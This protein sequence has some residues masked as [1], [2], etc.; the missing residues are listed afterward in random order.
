MKPEDF[1]ATAA[2]WLQVIVWV[3]IALFFAWIGMSVLD[4]FSS[5]S[6]S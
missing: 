6:R 1:F 3:A 2:A 4:A 5:F